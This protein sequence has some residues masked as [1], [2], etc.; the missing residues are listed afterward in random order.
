MIGS[1]GLAQAQRLGRQ[2]PVPEPI[3][4]A[5]DPDLAHLIDLLD[6]LSGPEVTS[7]WGEGDY[8]I[9]KKFASRLRPI[10]NGQGQEEDVD[11]LAVYVLK[12]LGKDNTHIPQEQIAKSLRGVNGLPAAGHA[13][14]EDAT[15]TAWTLVTRYSLPHWRGSDRHNAPGEHWLTAP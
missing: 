4:P 12:Y 6:M 3:T 7:L 14:V 11:Y 15:R 5:D 1:A 8:S 2:P 13:W 9:G 10:L